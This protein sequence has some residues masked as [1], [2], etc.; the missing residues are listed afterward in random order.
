ML[1]VFSYSAQCCTAKGLHNP[2]LE[3]TT[4]VNLC[5]VYCQRLGVFQ[6]HMHKRNLKDSSPGITGF[7]TPAGSLHCWTS[8]LCT[9]CMFD[10]FDL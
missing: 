6:H 3:E 8:A 9:D 1:P 7:A 10:E 5:A 2:A 4:T